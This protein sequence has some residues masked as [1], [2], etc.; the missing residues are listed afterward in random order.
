MTWEPIPGVLV[1]GITGRARHGKDELARALLRHITGAERFAFSDAV[2]AVARSL[3]LMGHRD[4]RVLQDVGTR[5]R[6]VEPETW[7]RCLYHA[8]QD[9][10]PGVAIITGVRYPNEAAM[11]REM[12]GHLVAV[13]RPY[14][15]A[16]TDRDP[17]HPVEQ[18][19]DQ[20]ISQADT[21]FRVNEFRDADALEA[22]FDQ[23]AVDLIE[24]WITA[25]CL[26]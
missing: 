13:E 25:P 2:A 4:P 24:S 9:K 12:G 14:A 23:M 7:L 22:C 20:L 26:P 16:L 11:I 1:V 15:P 17:A 8:I 5:L 21:V 19:I 6:Q 18:Q 3:Q 10:A